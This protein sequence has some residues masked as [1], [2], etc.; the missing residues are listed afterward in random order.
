MQNRYSKVESNTMYPPSD[1][2][3]LPQS[4]AT[5]DLPHIKVS[6]VPES[7]KEPTPVILLTLYRPNNNNAFT[8]QMQESVCTLYTMVNADDRVKVVVLTGHG[9][10]FCAGADLDIGFLGGASKSGSSHGKSERDI[11]HRDG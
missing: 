1:P 8:R 4:Y 9:K 6:H 7:S 11:D 3:Q 10:M 5:L 2:V